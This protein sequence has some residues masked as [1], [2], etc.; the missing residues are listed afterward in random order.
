MSAP[1]GSPPSD[2]PEGASCSP[3]RSGRR[4]PSSPY[5]S[6]SRPCRR[7]PAAASDRWAGFEDLPRSIVVVTGV[8]ELVA[9]FALVL[10]M[11]L[12]ILEWTT[13]LAA[14]GLAVVTLMASGFHV[15]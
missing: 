13:P 12:G 4:R 2:G 3:P 15:R 1:A 6:C 14:A 11:L 10:P 8:A 9:P 7:S 5:S